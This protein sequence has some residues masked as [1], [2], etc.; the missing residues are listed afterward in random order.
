[1]PNLLPTVSSYTSAN[2]LPTIHDAYSAAYDQ[3]QSWEDH[4]NPSQ[5]QRQ[6][7]TALP[8][9]AASS[10]GAGTDGGASGS[11]APPVSVGVAPGPSARWSKPPLPHY[12]A[13]GAAFSGQ[14]AASISSGQGG[15]AA[16]GRTASFRT[17]GGAPP[18]AYVTRAA[19]ATTGGALGRS[20][21]GGLTPVGEVPGLTALS[22]AS[23]NSTTDAVAPR[24]DQQQQQDRSG[25]RP[26]APATLPYAAPVLQGPRYGAAGAV[27]GVP[28]QGMSTTD[29][30]DGG[31]GPPGLGPGVAIGVP[32]AEG[33]ASGMAE[34][35]PVP[36][37]LALGAGGLSDADVVATIEVSSGR[38]RRAGSRMSSSGGGGGVTDVEEMAAA[39]EGGEGG[40]G[41]GE[42][43]PAVL[44]PAEVRRRLKGHL[45]RHRMKSVR[46]WTHLSHW[47]VKEGVSSVC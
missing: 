46:T 9:A 1:M 22:A 8:G 32:V 4:Q 11:T 2:P 44:L 13:G 20:A 17:A 33:V 5:Q 6:T 36:V 29:P 45:G 41:E 19:S 3:G 34:G 47:W 31:A 24:N 23:L 39:E 16:A 21:G 28:V 18:A 10:G 12:S 42:G 26:T 40:G 35:V 7:R 14:H 30:R 37:P 27:P 25:G 43:P 15:G 38:G